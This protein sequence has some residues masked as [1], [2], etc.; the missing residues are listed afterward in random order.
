MLREIRRELGWAAR[1]ALRT[2][3]SRMR[4]L[5]AIESQFRRSYFADEAVDLDAIRD[6]KLENFPK[7]GPSPWLDAPDAPSRIDARLASCGISDEQARQCRS[8]ARDGFLVLEKF[9]DPAALDGIWGA[10]E[11]AVKAGRVALQPDP[12]AAGDPL[13]SRSLDA[14]LSVPEVTALLH[15][16]GLKAWMRLLFGREPVPFQTLVSHKGSEQ[17]EHSDAIHMTTYPVGYLTA[18][19]IAF[20]DIRPD[21]GPIVYYPGSHRL[22]YL[23][24]GALGIPPGDFRRRG[25]AAYFE[26]YEPAIQRLIA[27][28]GLKPSV[29]LPKKGDVLVWHGNLIHAGSP[30]RDLSLSRKAVVLHYFAQGAVCYHDLSGTLTPVDRLK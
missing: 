4:S 29:F 30:R 28:N 3:R 14:H 15:D 8:W 22:P 20:E 7:S 2:A 11:E 19:W 5:A 9:F 13:P 16:E 12:P 10:Y 26:K 24:S 18:A 21:C 25:Y 6:Y 23:S 17:R 1:T 27:E